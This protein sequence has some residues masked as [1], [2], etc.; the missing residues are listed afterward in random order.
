MANTTNNSKQKTN[1]KEVTS[2]LGALSAKDDKE[3]TAIVTANLKT[4]IEQNG[5]T[6]KELAEKVGFV[7]LLCADIFVETSFHQSTFYLT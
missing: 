4:L 3:L 5:L 2:P 1:T 6:Q 7:K